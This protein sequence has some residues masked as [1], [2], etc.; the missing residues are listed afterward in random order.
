MGVFDQSHGGNVWLASRQ[1][2][3]SADSIIDFSSSI[4]PLAPPQRVIAAIEKALRW[5][6][7]YPDDGCLELAQRIAEETG[8]GRDCV[9]VGNGSVELIW[10]SASALLRRENRVLIPQPTFAEY[11]RACASAEARIEN[12]LVDPWR[13]SEEVVEKL[14]EPL[15]VDVDALYLCNPN[16]PTGDLL[17]PKRVLELAEEARAKKA[18]LFVDEAFCEFVVN[19]PKNSVAQLVESLENLVVFRSFTK[20]YGLAGL[21]VGYALASRDAAKRI[22]SAKPPWSVNTFAQEAAKEALGDR[23]FGERSRRFLEREREWLLQQ[24]KRFEPLRPK[25]SAANF[26]LFEV[27]GMTSTELAEKLL[28]RRVLVRDCQS[29][30]GLGKR[31]IRVSVKLREHNEALLKALEEA[32][33]DD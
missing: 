20:F 5:V 14:L 1:L 17:S 12:L 33:H 10:A 8:L 2:G 11:E 28:L 18:L 9:V 21:R 26:L 29:F 6:H 3:V 16:N 25:P 24:L 32:L 13:Y 15:D 23:G 19:Y 30:R 22:A 27:G 7:L 4:N 31:F